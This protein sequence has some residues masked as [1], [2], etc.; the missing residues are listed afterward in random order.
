MSIC[1]VQEKHPWAVLQ[2]AFIS[3]NII[4]LTNCK[5]DEWSPSSARPCSDCFN[6]CLL[7]TGP[8]HL[9][10]IFFQS[11][12]HSILILKTKG[13]KNPNPKPNQTKNK[14]K[15]A[16]PPPNKPKRQKKGEMHPPKLLLQLF[17]CNSRIFLWQIIHS[18]D[19][20][21]YQLHEC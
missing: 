4:S 19:P 3:S 2:H 1:T 6:C 13:K 8:G 5:P 7:V 21:K 11:S 16:P 9:N 15:K 20:A 14:T 17:T 10:V 12:T 18:E